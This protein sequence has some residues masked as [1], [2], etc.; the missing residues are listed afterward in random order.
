[1]SAAAVLA[2][3]LRARLPGAAGLTADSR[4]V[5]PGDVFLAMPGAVHDGR[6]HIPA[7]LAA[8]A[9]GIVW[10]AEGYAWP[11]QYEVANWPVAGLAGIAAGLAGEWWQRPSETLWMVG[12]TGTNGKTS[13]SHW[14]ADCLGRLG[15][16]TAVIGTLGN[17]FPDALAGASHT[18]PDAVS[19]QG[20][21]AGYR[22]A[23]AAGVAMEVSSHALDQGRVAG[24]AFDVAVLTN[25]SRD[26][27]DYHGD[28]A[29]YAHAKARLFD[30]PGLGWAVLNQEDELGRRLYADLAGRPVERLGY[31]FGAGEVR[32]S[33]LRLSADGL[34]MN[35]ATP[36]G[37]GELRAALMG[38]FNADNLL[39]CLAAL[40]ASGVDLEA[41]LAVLGQVRPAP[42][43]MQRV[44]G[45]AGTPTLVV[46]YAHTP[47]ALEK[48][49]ATLRP[50]TA[51]RLLCV[52]GCGG[53]R[54]RG[55]RPLMGEVAARLADLA[56]VTSDNPR[57]EDPAAIVAEIRAGMSGAERVEPDRGQAIAEAIALA[58]P[59]DVVLVAGKG[60]ED[61]QEVQGERRPFS[62]VAVAQQLLEE[63]VHASA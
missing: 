36:W 33:D 41:A 47:D 17:G 59:D 7:A 56:I 13:C 4:K 27:L 29:S 37:G 2:A 5:R 39:A 42:G 9:A 16:R 51:G 57:N 15:R 8:G 3:E 38:R 53:G 10:E 28:M 12:I 54:D 24:V 23:G 58:G 1:M 18:T 60:H 50:L 25:L 20:L 32:G 45:P 63:Q 34:A 6:A 26:H 21:L 19:L 35:V 48:A 31:G 52:F 55:K 49:L 62:D 22:D 44:A 30:W 11:A 61:Y 40:L 46:D 43:R 14:L